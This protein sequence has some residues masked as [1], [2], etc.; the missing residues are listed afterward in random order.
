MTSEDLSVEPNTAGPNEVE[1]CNS[2]TPRQSSLPIQN[3]HL[4]STSPSNPPITGNIPSTRL[5]LNKTLEIDTL[6]SN[7][8]E[9]PDPPPEGDDHQLNSEAGPTHN[10]AEDPTSPE[11]RAEVREELIDSWYHRE[12]D[13]YRAHLKWG[14]YDKEGYLSLGDGHDPMS[15]FRCGWSNFVFKLCNKLAAFYWR[16]PAKDDPYALGTLPFGCFF[17]EWFKYHHSEPDIKF[18]AFFTNLVRVHSTGSTTIQRIVDADKR[19]SNKVVRRGSR[20]MGKGTRFQSTAT[21]TTAGVIT[22]T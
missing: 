18:G 17:A 21:I 15:R 10:F 7:P 1:E 3:V 13:E 2:T 6:H 22:T 11:F 5:S 14:W 16:S 8:E 12:E 9:K 19:I 20:L 4:A